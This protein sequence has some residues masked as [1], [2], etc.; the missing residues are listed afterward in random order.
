[1]GNAVRRYTTFKGFWGFGFGRNPGSWWIQF[2]RWVWTTEEEQVQ[3][4]H[5][6]GE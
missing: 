2:A 5:G 4:F 6:R 1:M 3:W